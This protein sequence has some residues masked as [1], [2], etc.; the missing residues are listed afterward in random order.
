M[1]NVFISMLAAVIAASITSYALINMS[2]SGTAPSAKP[3]E[4]AYERVIRTGTIRCGYLVYDPEVIKDPNTGALS[5]WAIDIMSEAARKL[6]LQVDYVEEAPIASAFEG[7]KSG[8]YDALCTGMGETPERAREVIFTTPINYGLS[9][10][11]ARPEDHRFDTDFDAI[12]DPTVKIAVI[13][14]EGAQIVADQRFPKAARDRLPNLTP[15]QMVLD[16]VAAGKADIAIMQATPA[17][18]YMQANPGKVRLTSKTPVLAYPQAAGVFLNS[19]TQLK[20][21]VD[22]AIRALQLNGYVE[23]TLRKYN[24]Q[25]DSILLVNPVK[26]ESAE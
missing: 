12:N 14:G 9:F 18:L 21:M 13:D 2:K 16:E 1:R 20:S 17:N 23:Q 3:H 6:S 24:V 8:R 10:I 19:E 15:I 25:M 4:T 22:A 7:L 11:Y 26:S 5:G